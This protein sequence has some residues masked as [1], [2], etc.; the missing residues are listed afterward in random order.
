MR[1]LHFVAGT[2][3]GIVPKIVL[4]AFAGA[5]IVQL[6]KGEIGRHWVVVAAVAVLWLAIGWFARKWLRGRADNAPDER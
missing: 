1:S 2:G 3:I 4:T 6:M 5:S